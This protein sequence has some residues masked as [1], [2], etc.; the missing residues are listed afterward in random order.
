M[1]WKD[2]EGRQRAA[3]EEVSFAC[4]HFLVGKTEVFPVVSELTAVR[5]ASK[6]GRIGVGLVWATDCLRSL[7]PHSHTSSTTKFLNTFFGP[8]EHSREQMKLPPFR[9][10]I[11][12][13]GGKGLKCEPGPKGGSGG[14]GACGYL[15]QSLQA[16]G[17][18]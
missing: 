14:W 4:S 12:M 3:G 1:L 2:K 8:L 9:G 11:P 16:L 17:R 13:R 6:L 10:D 18:E 15:G 7:T 5:G